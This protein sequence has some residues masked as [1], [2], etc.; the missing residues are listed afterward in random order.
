MLLIASTADMLLF[1]T[2]QEGR[3]IVVLA[4]NV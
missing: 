4:V 3:T 1:V 2:V